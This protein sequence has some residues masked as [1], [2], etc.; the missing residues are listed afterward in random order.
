MD[1][2]YKDYPAMMPSWGWQVETGTHLLRLMSG[3]VFDRYPYLKIIVGHMGELI[4]FNLK[5]I[6]TALTLGNCLLASQSKDV[7]SAERKA[8]QKSVFYYMREN[9]FITTSGSHQCK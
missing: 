7:K 9:V 2:Y 6:N 8:M 1:I 4:P 5:R 3:G